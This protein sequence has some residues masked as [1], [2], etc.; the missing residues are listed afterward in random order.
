MRDLESIN[1]ICAM[2]RLSTTNISIGVSRFMEFFGF[3]DAHRITLKNDSPFHKLTKN[4]V[5][6][7]VPS[8]GQLANLRRENALTNINASRKIN[9]KVIMAPCRND[10][11]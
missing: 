5:L 7:I 9:L 4:L 8:L 2:A 10:R 3:I 1:D 6:A 11:S